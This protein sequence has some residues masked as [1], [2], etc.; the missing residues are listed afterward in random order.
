MMLAPRV[1]LGS[2]E[3]TAPLGD[4]GMGVV[5]PWIADKALLKTLHLR[6][7][8]L[9]IGRLD[10]P[11]CRTARRSPDLQCSPARERPH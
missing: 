4:G 5:G 1:R 10:R 8:S 3:R 11:P 6:M 9:Q 7:Q 2:S